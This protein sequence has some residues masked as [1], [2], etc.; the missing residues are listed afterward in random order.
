MNYANMD[1]RDAVRELR[2]EKRRRREDYVVAAVL[3]LGT[4]AMIAVGRVW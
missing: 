3:V 4:A 2:A 1:I